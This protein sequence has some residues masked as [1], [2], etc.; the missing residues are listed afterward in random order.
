MQAR[1]GLDSDSPSCAR[2]RHI[3]DEYLE[4]VRYLSRD[5]QRQERD[6]EFDGRSLQNCGVAGQLVPLLIGSLEAT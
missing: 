3:I 2:E 5:R 6:F 4:A 1:I